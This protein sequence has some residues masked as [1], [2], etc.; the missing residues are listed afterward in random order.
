MYV[1]N[2]VCIFSGPPAMAKG[3][4]PTST[5]Q[6]TLFSLLQELNPYNRAQTGRQG[7]NKRKGNQGYQQSAP[8][9]TDRE[10]RADVNFQNVHMFRQYCTEFGSIKLRDKKALKAATYRKLVRSV[11]TARCM[12]L[13]P[14]VGLHP[15]FESEETRDTR[16][17][18]E[19][20]DKSARRLA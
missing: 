20:M 19:E 7:G 16:L 8:P 2:Y 10:V 17:T 6:M 11:K 9:Y 15:Q 13:A 4:P 14:F 12:A 3:R 18:F 1:Y 5:L